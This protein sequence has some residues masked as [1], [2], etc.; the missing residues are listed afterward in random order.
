LAWGIALADAAYAAKSAPSVLDCA[1]MPCA[2]VLPEAV[3][4]RPVEDV[5]YQTGHDAEGNVIGWVALSTD[6]VDI[7][8]YSGK[9]LV[10]LVG[11]D[12]EGVITGARVLHHSEPILLIG[13][14]ESALSDFVE[15]Y[16]GKPATQRIV[17]GRSTRSDA[18]AVDVISGATVTVLAQNHTILEVARTLGVQVGVIHASAVSPGTFV[19]EALTLHVVQAR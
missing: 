14:P 6:F 18:V 3:E 10:T 12:P 11:L 9:P 19:E 5:L 4:F 17:V 13:I 15:F 1:A 16:A 8:A 7:K 2:E